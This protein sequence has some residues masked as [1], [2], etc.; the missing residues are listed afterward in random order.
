MHSHPAE[1]TVHKKLS[2][3]G[4]IDLPDG[5]NI[6]ANVYADLNSVA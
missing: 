3:L 5:G 4:I 6:Q 2:E 1:D